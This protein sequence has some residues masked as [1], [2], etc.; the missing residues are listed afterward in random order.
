MDVDGVWTVDELT[1][2]AFLS[3]LRR[4][5]RGRRRAGD[6][7]RGPGPDP[8]R[9]APAARRH[10]GRGLRGLPRQG[11]AA[12]GRAGPLRPGRQRDAGPD[13]RPTPRSRGTLLNSLAAVPDPALPNDRLAA[14]LSALGAEQQG[15]HYQMQTLAGAPGRQRAAGPGRR[16]QGGRAAAQRRR[17]QPGQRRPDP[18]RRDRR[19]RPHGHRLQQRDGRLQAPQRRLHAAD[20]RPG[21]EQPRRPTSRCRTPGGRDAGQADRRDPGPGGQRGQ[22]GAVRHHAGRR[23]GGAGPGL[24][25]ASGRCRPTSPRRTCRPTC[26]QRRAP[27]RA[28]RA[29]RAAGPE[30][31]KPRTEETTPRA[32][33][34]PPGRERTRRAGACRGPSACRAGRDRCGSPYRPREPSGAHEILETCC[35]RGARAPARPTERNTS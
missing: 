20:A 10:Q 4:R 8:G 9:Q 11:R 17:P 31:P 24:D 35:H 16:V 3:N 12:G 32:R 19:H 22:G 5:L 25:A 26:C 28:G 18:G 34:R 7:P 29:P 14:I 1:F 15:A 6:Q 21:A 23:Q 2:A 27:G 13:A 30:R 33:R